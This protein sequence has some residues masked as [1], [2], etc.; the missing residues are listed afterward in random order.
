MKKLFTFLLA[1]LITAINASASAVLSDDGK[2]LTLNNFVE[3]DAV[4][5]NVDQFTDTQ[6]A[7]VKTLIIVGSIGNT[8]TF[9]DK[10]AS[11]VT[12]LEELDMSG[13]DANAVVPNV[14]GIKAMSSIKTIKF[15]NA[16]EAIPAGLCQG[17]SNLT[18][19]SLPTSL[20]TIEANAFQSCSALQEITL[21]YGLE[22]ISGE[23]FDQSGLVS[24]SIPGSVKTIKSDAFSVCR[25][26]HRVVFEEAKSPDVVNM[27]I[28]SDAFQNGDNVWDVYVETQGTIVCGNEAFSLLATIGQTQTERRLAILHFPAN[29][30]KDY[31]NQKHVLTPAIAKNPALFQP[32]LS[33]HR[34]AAGQ[35]QNGWYEFVNSAPAEDPDDPTTV[36]GEKFL[37][38]WSE[39][40]T[41]QEAWLVNE[42][43]Y[44][45]EEK[46]GLTAE[47]Q[48]SAV[49]VSYYL[50][51]T[52][53]DGVRAYI[54]NSI[55]SEDVTVTGGG[56]EKR[57]TVTLKRIQAIPP[58]TGVILYGESNTVTVDGTPV[59]SMPQT[60]YIGEPLSREYWDHEDSDGEKQSVKLKNYL[61]A[62]GDAPKNVGPYEYKNGT[63]EV[64]YR[65]FLLG[66]FAKTDTYRKNY[67]GNT[68]WEVTDDYLGFFRSKAG[69]LSAR[70]AYLKLKNITEE[71]PEPKGYELVV[72]KDED[73]NK[74][75]NASGTLI[76][77]K[78]K[79][80]TTETENVYWFGRNWTDRVVGSDGGGYDWGSR[81]TDKNLD[82]YLV[83]Y[84]G[85]FE[86]EVDG[87][88]TLTI[89]AEV[90][91]NEYYTLQGVNVSN[92]TK[93]GIYIKNGKKVIIK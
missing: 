80:G 14:N 15:P 89:P 9:K 25:S 7:G 45:D 79:P 76:P 8:N 85:E 28:E 10:I 71:F 48:S 53:P 32:W 26:L 92:P 29:K 13:M 69:S 38:T 39:G 1:V 24:I 68:N 58:M 67:E 51:R 72:A 84:R 46:A 83:S 70:K 21:P 20:K 64:E 42:L 60:P 44:T 63:T 93:S 12:G 30:A 18:S 77:S 57:Y 55:S 87:I 27:T 17:F 90:V 19:V 22:T 52:V 47:Q 78:Q 86:H 50:A 73:Y 35:S 23:A 62:T 2:T 16:L 74:E 36:K 40:G 56:T 88:V 59:L 66:R 4:V 43:L 81:P 61:I 6:L 3:A 91:N 11:K 34:T 37:K 33:R 31:V 54:V 75:Y 5:N 82:D 41:A 49:K 65:N